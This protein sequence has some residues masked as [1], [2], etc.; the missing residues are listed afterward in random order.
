MGT[1]WVGNISVTRSDLPFVLVGADH[2]C[3]PINIETKTHAGLLGISNN[4]NARQW[5]L[6]AFEHLKSIYKL[7]IN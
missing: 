6:A 5:F 3:E 2:A 7:G 4:V 1:A